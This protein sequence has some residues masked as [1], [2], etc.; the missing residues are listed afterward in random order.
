MVVGI[1]VM[2]LTRG[3]CLLLASCERVVDC[4]LCVSCLCVCV[5]VWNAPLQASRLQM[6]NVLA[7]CH[8]L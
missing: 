8:I 2:C 5:T 7:A 3:V 6:M 1:E 4:V